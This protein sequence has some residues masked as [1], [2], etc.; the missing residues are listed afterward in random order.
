[1]TS[2]WLSCLL[3][4][5]LSAAFDTVDCII[6]LDICLP[7][8][9]APLFS[10]LQIL[11][12]GCLCGSFPS[13]CSFSLG[14]SQGSILIP[15]VFSLYALSLGDLIH[16]YVITCILYANNSCRYFSI[17]D[18]PPVLASHSLGHHILDCSQPSQAKHGPR[19]AYHCL[20]P[21]F[22]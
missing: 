13:P 8:A 16:S 21:L 15:F 18:L 10:P 11:F 9:Y 14:V 17:L 20:C 22:L 6:F 12:Q 4:L 7:L 5:E 1:M 19:V 3:L 2:F